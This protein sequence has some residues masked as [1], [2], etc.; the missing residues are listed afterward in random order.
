[1][2]NN[3]IFDRF[4][5][6]LEFDWRSIARPEQ[7][8]PSDADWLIWLYLAGRGAGK[9]RSGAEGVREWIETG[10]CRRVALI[11]P[12]AADARDVMI[13]GASGIL[14]VC[15]PSNRPTFEPSKRRL[16]WP[17]NR[18]LR[19]AGAIATVYSAEEADRLRGPQ[20][21]GL[22]ADELAAWKDAQAVWDQAMFGLR[23]GKKPR[24]I[25]T[26]TPRPIKIIRDLLAR[27]GKDVR[28]TRGST[29]D[30]AANLAP[31]FLSQIVGRYQ[32]TRLGRQE[33]DAEILD[34]VVGA[35]WS[36][37]LLEQQ[38]RDA[39]P[40]LSRI[41]VAIDPSVS[42]SEGADECGLIVAGLGV[43]NH[44]Y[45]LED[46]S[47]VMSPIEWARK[48]VQLFKTWSADRVV[49][50]VNNGGGLVEAQLRAVDTNVPYRAVHAS[51]SK[52]TRA[53]PIAALFEQGRAHLVGTFPQLE[54]QLST[55]SAG[56]SDSPDRLDSMVWALTELALNPR[57]GEFVWG[58]I[59]PRSDLEIAR[60]Y[61]DTSH[62]H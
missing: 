5:D 53:E 45:V 58:G 51:R 32:G 9:T 12:T 10:R 55:F 59:E 44:A 20:H 61:L 41:V 42:S 11:A 43:D 48:A 37:S 17:D 57:R 62:Y 47:G 3:E 13:E 34:D 35:L 56:S 46:A 4:A 25:I 6:R 24:A 27:D 40:A 8:M 29:R 28:V 22:W 14:A 26:T 39:A 30:N 52:I 2:S 18:S 50:E 19:S 23:V 21:D 16:T 1:M 36:R 38:R 33:L 54:D 60:H 31:S 15:P 49:A 7:R